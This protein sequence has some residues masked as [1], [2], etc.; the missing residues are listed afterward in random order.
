MKDSPS[1]DL[2]GVGPSSA[3]GAFARSGLVAAS[4]IALGLVLHRWEIAALAAPFVLGP[5]MFFPTRAASPTVA[6]RFEELAA[7][8]HDLVHVFV[9]VSAEHALDAVEV[10]LD[11]GEFVPRG[12]MRWVVSLNAAQ[13]KEFGTE[14]VADHWGRRRVGPATAI[15]L[16][17]GLFG[18][19]APSRSDLAALEVEPEPETFRATQ[20]V[21]RARFRR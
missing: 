8:E 9:T 13:S 6:L 14:V 19:M 3:N 5:A 12:P 17:P 10:E 21:P 20:E 16:T 7:G 4:A 1:A 2:P 11:P 18:D 15:A